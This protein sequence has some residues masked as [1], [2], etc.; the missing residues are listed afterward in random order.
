MT[1]CHAV[2][3]L[4]TRPADPG[5][6]RYARSSRLA[7]NADRTRLMAV[8]RA[9]SP[10]AA[11]HLL[12]R[13]LDT[14][15]PLDVLNTHYPDR[16]WQVLLNVALGRATGRALRRDAAARGQRPGD[17]LRQHVT[18]ALAREEQRRARQLKKRL[19]PLLTDHTPEEVLAGAAALL[20]ERQDHRPLAAP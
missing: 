18:I 16:H 5:E 15:L 14:H 4:L 17:V 13:R 3:I 20:H 12:R 2:E 9:P 7:V 1:P 6:L 8:Q 19:T 11:L 10:G